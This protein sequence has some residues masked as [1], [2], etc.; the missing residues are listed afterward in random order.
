M[1]KKQLRFKMPNSKNAFLTLNALSLMLIV[2]SASASLPIVFPGPLKQ[3]PNS[4]SEGC[5]QN[6][7]GCDE[8]PRI[9]T[10]DQSNK[11][12]VMKCLT[13]PSNGNSLE[14]D[15]GIA[16]SETDDVDKVRPI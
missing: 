16:K 8:R 12:P 4:R 3:R 14:C 9:L 10:N 11:S 7:Y 2:A 1:P 15:C 5:G 13:N 6:V